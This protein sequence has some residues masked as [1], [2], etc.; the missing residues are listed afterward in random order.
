MQTTVHGIH[1]VT[2]VAGDAQQNLDFYVGILGMRMVKKTVNQDA[3]HIYHL[4]YADGAGTPGTD[5]T[6]FPWPDIAPTPG[7]IGIG[8]TVEVPFAIRQ[9]SLSY[10]R[11]RLATLGVPHDPIETRF[12]EPTLPFSDPDGLRLALVETADPRQV[13]PW[14]FSP[15]PAEHQVRG[16]H[17]VRMWQ[18]ELAPTQR[19]LTEQMGFALLGTEDGWQRYGVEGGGSGKCIDIKELPNQRRGIVGAG[20]V[21]H[22]AWRMTDDREEM[23]LHDAV[24]SAG[25]HPTPQIDRFWFRSVYFKEPGG[26]L[27]ELATDGPGFDRDEDQ[28]H[29]GEQLILAPWLEQRRAE[30]EA[31]LTPLELPRTDR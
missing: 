18:R 13:V 28:A 4:F 2:A 6:F 17:Y 30:I 14:D 10:W 26:A 25:L 8:L 12:G 27:F 1:H 24:E 15:V 5:I 7:R 21:H 16:M 3:P 19:L 29:L 9:G 20:T 23:A 22:V 31:V 11:E